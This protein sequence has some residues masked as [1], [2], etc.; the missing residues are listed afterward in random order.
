MEYHS[1]SFSCLSN[2]QSRL[3]YETLKGAP[4]I[5]RVSRVGLGHCRWGMIGGCIVLFFY[6]FQKHTCTQKAF[7]LD[8]GATPGIL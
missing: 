4:Q 1:S 6:L 7:T 3:S 5:D 8:I 2:G